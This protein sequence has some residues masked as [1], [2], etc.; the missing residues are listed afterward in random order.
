MKSKQR[1]KKLHKQKIKERREREEK[2]LADSTFWPEKNFKNGYK[3][4]YVRRK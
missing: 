4:H 3:L 1:Q 2:E